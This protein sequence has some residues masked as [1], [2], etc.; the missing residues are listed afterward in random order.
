MRLEGWESR[1]AT[2]IELARV[3]PYHLGEHD[4]F[5]LACAAVEAL[6]GIDR[7][8]EWRGRY[9][10]RTEAVRLLQS[11]VDEHGCQMDL[12]MFTVAFS[13]FFG[14]E[15]SA[16]RLA[17]RGDIVEYIDREPHLGIIIGRE[18]A[19][20]GEDGLRFVPLASC[21]HAWRIG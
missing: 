20:L 14:I 1:L 12:P 10:T 18:A 8:P 19:V 17:R 4:C 16:V 9:A 15:P 21:N 3:T 13:H 5:R 11:Y 6:T 7:W 2:V